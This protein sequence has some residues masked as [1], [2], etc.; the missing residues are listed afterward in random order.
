MLRTF[1]AAEAV[2]L[3]PDLARQA[4]RRGVRLIV[5]ADAALARALGADGVHL[6]ERM[7]RRRGWIAA[8]RRRFLVTAAVHG[9]AAI[10][11]AQ[12]SEID[13]LVLSAVFPSQSPSA[14]RPIGPRRF[15][16]LARLA[17]P[18]VIALGGVNSR[19]V[20]RLRGSG[21]AGVACV[22]GIKEATGGQGGGPR[23]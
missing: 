5:G 19:T 4:R 1:G 9:E 2:R 21:A 17:T 16:A 23:T 6:P 18:P 11:A 15:A 7:S 20:R 12:R 3:G 8:L 13:A 14:G 10:R 22:S